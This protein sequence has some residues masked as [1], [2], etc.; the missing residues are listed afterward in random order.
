MSYRYRSDS[1]NLG[2]LDARGTAQILNSLSA[3]FSAVE[4]ADFCTVAEELVLRDQ[5]IVVGK[6]GKLPRHLR[7]TLQPLLDAGVLVSPGE[8]FC[9]P[10]LPSDPRQLRATARAIERGL[11]TATIEDATYEARRLLGG[12]AHFGVVA[13]PLLRQLQHFGLV[14]RPCVENTQRLN[15]SPWRVKDPTLQ[16]S[17]FPGHGSTTSRL[18]LRSAALTKTFTKRR[19]GFG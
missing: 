1:S 14:R 16:R 2:L 4:F 6:L 10:E 5:I 8:A 3:R 17:R 7:L 13:T 11:T 12:E 18:R 15:L 19:R 9:V